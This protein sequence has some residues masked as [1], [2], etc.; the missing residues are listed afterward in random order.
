MNQYNLIV[1]IFATWYLSYIL[2]AQSGPFLILERIRNRVG[3][4]LNCIYCTSP[5][6]AAIV[7]LGIQHTTWGIDVAQ[8]FAIAGAGLM[9]RSY[10]GA[11]LHD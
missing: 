1:A 7:W 4:A 9:L 2:T 6:V 11:G 3:G 5:Y 10:T 8:I